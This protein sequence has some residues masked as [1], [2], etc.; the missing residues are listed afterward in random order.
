MWDNDLVEGGPSEMSSDAE[1][2]QLWLNLPPRDKMTEPAVQI[3]SPHHEDVKHEDKQRGVSPSSSSMGSFEN[4]ADVASSSSVPLSVVPL[5]SAQPTN[6]DNAGVKVRVLA[7][8]NVHGVTSATKT[9]SPVTIAH[10]TLE[11]GGSWSLPLPPSFTAI[12]YVRKVV[13]LD[14]TCTYLF[15]YTCP[16][17]S[18][19]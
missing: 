3:V 4:S 6:E 2:Y 13:L 15:Y 5:H 17:C 14:S 7:G 9:H 1:L 10:A 16:N 11:P 12:I 8:S 19:S 18:R